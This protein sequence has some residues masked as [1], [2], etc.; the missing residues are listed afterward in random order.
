MPQSPIIT[1]SSSEASTPNTPDIRTSAA[2]RFSISQSSSRSINRRSSRMSQF[3]HVVRNSDPRGDSELNTGGGVFDL[4]GDWVRS[5]RWRRKIGNTNKAGGV[6]TSEAQSP[7][8]QLPELG[9]VGSRLELST[10][11]IYK[12][13]GE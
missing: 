5:R 3:L 1:A 6:Q 10:E 11:Q 2:S 12:I 8:P 13:S 7:P 9:L 4:M